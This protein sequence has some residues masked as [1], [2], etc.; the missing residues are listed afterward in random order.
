MAPVELF[1][2]LGGYDS[3]MRRGEDTDFNIRLALAG[4]YFAGIADPLVT[5]TMTMGREKTFDAERDAEMHILNKHREYLAKNGVEKFVR[6]WLELR[7]QYL[8]SK[9]LAFAWQMMLISLLHPV[10]VVRKILWTRP[11]RA[12]R[13]HFKSWHHKTEHTV[14]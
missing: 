7:Y 8:K 10:M 12:T 4:G 1:R 5:Q 3:G 9:W 11:A 2:A 14:S 13:Q 6:R